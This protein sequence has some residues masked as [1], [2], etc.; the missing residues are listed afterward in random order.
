MKQKAEKSTAVFKGLAIK[1]VIVVSALA[2]GLYIPTPTQVSADLN[3]EIADLEKQIDSYQSEVARLRGQANTYQNAFNQLNAEKNA[4]QAQVDLSQARYDKL[5]SDIAANEKKMG[6]QQKVMASAISDL[7]AE[8]TTSPIEVLASSDS[9][10]DYIDQQEY[11][12]S[13][14][15]QLQQS[16]GQIKKIK[17]ELTKQKEDVKIV[18]ED[19]KA[20]R[21][22]LSAKEAE[23]A[24]LLAATRGEEAAYQSLIGQ[25]N[26]ELADKRAAQAAAMRGGNGAENIVWGSSSYPWMSS[27]MAYD[28]YCNYFSGGSAADPFGYC[29]R[30]CVSYVAWKLNTDGRGNHGYSGLGNA[31]QWGGGGYGVSWG[32]LQAGDV[33]IWYVGGYGHVMYV[34]SISGT[35]VHISQMNVPYDSGQYSTADYQLS[36]LMSGPYDA[37]RFH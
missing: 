16:I 2:L 14:R 8:S 29:K 36:T 23:Q 28:D 1:A 32:G 15:D 20:Q 26:A 33:I 3:S 12:S 25:K 11:R 17:A 5:V 30:Q 10:G 24:S 34:E 35:T 22:Q 7:A 6:E 18:L 21:D 37:R 27:S 4:I 9:I 13:I 19:Q 31:N